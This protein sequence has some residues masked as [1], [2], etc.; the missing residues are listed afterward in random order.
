MMHKWTVSDRGSRVVRYVAMA[1]G[2]E[3]D[4]GFNEKA[5]APHTITHKSRHTAELLIPL[6]TCPAASRSPT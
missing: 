4:L 3:R 5:Y 6:G 1:S 2:S